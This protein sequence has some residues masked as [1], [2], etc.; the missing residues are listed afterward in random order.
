M[1]TGSVAAI[2]HSLQLRLSSIYLFAVSVLGIAM[3]FGSRKGGPGAPILELGSWWSSLTNSRAP[4]A[5]SIQIWLVD[6][7][8]SIS[9]LPW[10]I[11]VVAALA[12]AKQGW[13]SV[14]TRTGSTLVLGFALGSSIGV[15]SLWQFVVASVGLM[16]CGFAV[17]HFVQR[18]DSLDGNDI[19]GV[20]I[21][22]G[23]AFVYAPLVILQWLT[24]RGNS[25]HN[26][27][28]NRQ[29]AALEKIAGQHSG[30]GVAS[31]AKAASSGNR[32]Q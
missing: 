1:I 27:I 5:D 12:L 18:D 7:S 11:V 4:W 28:R 30:L 29:V 13:R 23:L 20:I 14:A 26:A 31:G 22:V 6:R 10:L 3:I 24:G 21:S 8:S 15:H 17:R 2:S 19:G 25:E 32:Y 9:W 16:A